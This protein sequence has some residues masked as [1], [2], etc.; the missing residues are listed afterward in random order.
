MTTARAC[1]VL[2][3]GACSA[4]LIGPAVLAA[5]LG[6]I[7]PTALNERLARHDASVIVVDV[8]TPE[9]FTQAHVPGAINIPY[10]TLAARQDELTGAKNKDVVLYCR[11]GRRSKIA[12]DTLEAGGFARLLQLEGNIQGWEDAKLPVDK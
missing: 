3:L 5:D 4:L 7:T 6:T 12:A 10:D 8:R 2:V 1:S 9:E 11:T